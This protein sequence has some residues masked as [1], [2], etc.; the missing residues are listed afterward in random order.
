MA[1]SQ[2]QNLTFVYQPQAAFGQITD[3]MG[4]V[5][6]YGLYLGGQNA[7]SK[8]AGAILAVSTDTANR[9]VQVGFNVG[10]TGTVPGVITGGTRYIF[11]TTTVATGA[12]ATGAVPSGNL[13][14]STMPT[15]SDG[16]QYMFIPANVYFIL[17]LPVGLSSGKIMNFYAPAIGDF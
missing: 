8:L 6:S 15:D 14:P 17:S 1:F 13:L 5:S 11:W 16:E 7:G 2:N 3:A 9:D 10:G 4:A 12:G